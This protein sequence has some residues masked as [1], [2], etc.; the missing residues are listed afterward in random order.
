MDADT[1]AVTDQDAN[2]TTFSYSVTGDDREV[3]AFD[4]NDV[5]GFK[6][7]HKPDYEEKN[8]YSITITARS[9]GRSTTLDVTIEVVDTEDVGE[10]SLSQRQP[11][12]GIAVH[13]TASD[14]DGGVSIKRWE[15]ERSAEITVDDTRTRRPSAGTTLTR[16]A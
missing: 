12:V 8:S 5:L 6:P 14:P 15:W 4:S 1:F 10:V 13:A 9:R 2:D 11:Q 3:L 16:P 7:D